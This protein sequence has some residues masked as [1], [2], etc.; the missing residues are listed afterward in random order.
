VTSGKNRFSIARTNILPAQE[1]NNLGRVR[2]WLEET[3]AYA[4]RGFERSYWQ[5]QPIQSAAGECVVRWVCAQWPPV[6][7]R[8]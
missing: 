7:F 3:A 4:Q 5:R 6:P 1:Q 2:Q 8:R